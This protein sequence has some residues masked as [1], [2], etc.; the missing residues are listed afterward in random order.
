MGLGCVEPW[1]GYSSIGCAEGEE[2]GRVSHH[3]G[4]AFADAQS[5]PIRTEEGG[6]G[7]VYGV[8]EAREQEQE[9][10]EAESSEESAGPGQR[11]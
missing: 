5:E 6:G 1:L 4:V 11:R 8:A 3:A 9:S 10:D 7:Q 2:S